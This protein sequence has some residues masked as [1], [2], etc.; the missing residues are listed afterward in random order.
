MTTNKILVSFQLFIRPCS[1][2]NWCTF[3]KE[4]VRNVSILGRTNTSQHPTKTT[5]KEANNPNDKKQKTKDYSSAIMDIAYITY[6]IY[7]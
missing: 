3:V 4:K 5:N 6:Y 1:H 2:I 7:I